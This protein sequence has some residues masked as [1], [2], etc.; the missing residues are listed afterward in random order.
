MLKAQEDAFLDHTR[1]LG[2]KDVSVLRISAGEWNEETGWR[3]GVLPKVEN[4]IPS[5]R[6]VVSFVGTPP[7]GMLKSSDAAPVADYLLAVMPSQ[8]HLDA[9]MAKGFV[10][11]AI[12][13]ALLTDS[14][15]IPAG[16][17]LDAWFSAYFRLYDPGQSDRGAAPDPENG[18]REPEV[19]W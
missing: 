12:V 2:V 10:H 6:V 3:S 9:L 7:A 15:D 1:S 17:P 13:P 16:A 14:P 18:N 4:D 19:Q 5:S 11:D 8:K